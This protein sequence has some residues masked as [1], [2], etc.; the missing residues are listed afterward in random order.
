MVCAVAGPPRAVEAEIEIG[1]DAAH[2]Q[3]GLSVIAAVA[4][5]EQCRERGVIPAWTC[6]SKNLPSQRTAARLGFRKFR[7][8]MGFR[9]VADTLV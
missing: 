9:M 2:R 5:F 7:D 4:F 6:D 3:K 1:T 8:V